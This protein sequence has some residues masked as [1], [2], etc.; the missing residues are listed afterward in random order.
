MTEQDLTVIEY[1]LGTA[2][3]GPW[4]VDE[5]NTY[6][7]QEVAISADEGDPR[8]GLNKWDSLVICYGS[9]D[10]P[11]EGHSVAL[12]NASLIAHARTDLEGLVNEVRRLKRE[13][14]YAQEGVTEQLRVAR[15]AGAEAMRAAIVTK[16]QELWDQGAANIAAGVAVPECL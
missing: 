2:T 8:L 4:R 6:D 16:M 10:A 13:L 15:N 1:R 11:I 3:P 14:A 12:A 5:E 7:P 9:D